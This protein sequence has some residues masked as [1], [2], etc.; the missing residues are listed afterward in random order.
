MITQFASAAPNIVW[1][2]GEDASPNLSCYGEKTIETPRLDGLAHEGV[3]FENAFVTCPVCSPSRSAMVT[4][5]Y[6]TTLGAH[7]HRSQR[8]DGKGGGNEDYYESYKLPVKSIPDLFKEAGYATYNVGWEAGGKTKPGKTDYNFIW[9]PAMYDSGDWS[10]RKEGQPFFAQ[11]QLH[12]GKNR[13]A[14]QH[15]TDPNKVNLPP[16]YPDDPVL[17][18]DWAD[19]LNSWIQMDL[20][21]GE[22]LD[23]LEKENLTENTFVFF[24]TDHGISHMRDK[25]FLYDGG[26]K[27][28]LIVRFPDGSQNGAVRKDLVEHIDIAATSLALADIPIPDRVQG[29]NLFSS[30]HEPREFIFA[31]RDRCDETVDIIR[32]VRT[33]RYKYIRNF[34]SYLPHAQPNQYKDGK[35][36]LKR[37]KIL[38]QA[39]ELSELQAR[40]YQSPRPT[41]ELYDIQNDPYE[42][43]NLAGDP[44]HEEVLTS[45]RSRLYKSMIETQDVGLIP[46][47]VL[48]EMG[49]EAGNKY[50]VLDRP[51]NEDLIEE[52]IDTI[53]AGE[54]G[55]KAKLAAAL[56]SDQPAVR[57]WAA[58]WLGVKGGKRAI[59]SLNPLFG[60]PSPGVRVAAALAAG[61][62]GETEVAVKLLAD[63]ID[64]P[65][66]VV[67]MFA[68][69]AIELLNP[70][71][72]DQIP[73][74]VAAKES[75]Y[76]FT[77]RIAN[78]I[79]S[80]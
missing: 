15:G 5:M 39:G 12:G 19:Y 4:G 35:E 68:I 50:F 57:Y 29:R 34:M 41:E 30:S 3:R 33:D 40:V 60:D 58:M 32:C 69:R 47:P 70:P 25:Q 31:A 67:G 53:E 59:D 36:I 45:L 62:L 14:K 22:I 7:N 11:I 46:E 52:L 43:R 24:W 74:V 48:E 66:L 65:N 23:R 1:I 27:V 55:D 72:A 44:A 13:K 18:E 77:Q 63:H 75:P 49:K 16:Y 73:E 17:R 42:T 9:D 2:I 54:N 61:R 26:I 8:E 71:N 79:A 21:V 64:H 10:N 20:E 37:I 28:P 38:Y 78:R 76:E 80:K 56:K 6:Q 51:E